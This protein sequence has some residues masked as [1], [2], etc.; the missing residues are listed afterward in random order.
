MLLHERPRTGGISMTNHVP[1]TARA[2]R[3]GPGDYHITAT[4]P[5]ATRRP[6]GQ[7]QTVHRAFRIRRSVHGSWSVRSSDVPGVL[8][9]DRERTK[10]D[11]RSRLFAHLAE[12]A[13]GIA[14]RPAPEPLPSEQ[15]AMSRRKRF[16]TAEDLDRSAA[17]AVL[18]DVLDP[19][20]KRVTL[21]EWSRTITAFLDA[22]YHDP[23][24]NMYE[25]AKRWTTTRSGVL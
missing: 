10:D 17:D 12:M 4:F 7:F 19:D 24:T 8:I 18:L 22:W 15:A 21:D 25:F 14:A 3:V 23:S 13:P 16:K 2:E 6:D 20:A 1:F 11:A 5:T 9:A